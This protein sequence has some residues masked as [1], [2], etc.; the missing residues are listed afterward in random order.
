MNDLL[1][2]ALSLLVGAGLGLF[3]FGG[4]WLTVQRL[5]TARRPALLALGSFWGRTVVTVAVLYLIMDGHWQRLVA[6]MAG[7]VIVR[8]ILVGREKPEEPAAPEENRYDH[9]PG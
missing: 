3:Y 9:Q 8:L 4:L 1:A 6:A 2:L 7:F 5:P